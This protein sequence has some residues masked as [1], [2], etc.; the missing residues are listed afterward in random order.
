MTGVFLKIYDWFCAHRKTAV[1]TVI[2]ITLLSVV[3]LLRL[4]YEED[5]A[6]F[7][8]IDRSDS[9]Q[10]ELMEQLSRQKTALQ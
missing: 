5:I 6:G 9:R 2:A 7:L 3:S 8:P 4:H 1:I 10:T